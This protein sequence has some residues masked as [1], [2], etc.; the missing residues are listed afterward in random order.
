M[1]DGFKLKGK[2]TH[3]KSKKNS[4]YSYYDNSSRLL[5]GLYIENNLY[6]ISEDYV[7]V[8]KLNDLTEVSS[9]KIKED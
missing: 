4:K 6:T 2:I 3:D 1:K 9:L 8:N 5:R 7:K